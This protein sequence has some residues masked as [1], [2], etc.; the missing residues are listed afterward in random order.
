[1]PTVE[2]TITIYEKSFARTSFQDSFLITPEYLERDL[3][4][5]EKKQAVRI[6]KRAIQ[7]FHKFNIGE[8]GYPPHDHAKSPV[9]KGE[10]KK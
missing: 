3:K 6:F 1:M 7:S 10:K 4:T 2:I 5:I 9:S 8:R